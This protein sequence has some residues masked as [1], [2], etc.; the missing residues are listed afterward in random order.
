MAII[1]ILSP[2]VLLVAGIAFLPVYYIIIPYF[3][4]YRHL[5]GIPA[6]FPAQFTSLWLMSISRE[7][8]R[9]EYIDALHRRLGPVVRIQPNHVS[10]ADDKAINL[11]YG[12]GN[13]SL[14]S[15]WYDTFRS[16]GYSVFNTRDR[17]QHSHKRRIVAH[18]FAPKS[19]RQMEPCFAQNLKFLIEKWDDIAKDGAKTDGYADLDCRRWINFFA[20]DVIGDIIFGSPFGMLQAGADLAESRTTREGPSTLLPAVKHLSHRSEIAATL[21]AIPELKP[22]AQYIPDPYFRKGL[23][24]VK[25]F[26][27]V[28]IARV[29]DRWENPKQPEDRQDLL[30][31]LQEGSD[32]KGDAFGFEEL[33]AEALTLLIAGSDT[34]NNTFCAVM[35]HLAANPHAMSRLQEEVDAALPADVIVPTH[36]MVKNL[37]YL[38]SVINETLRQHSTIGLGLPRDVPPDSEGIHFRGHYFPAGTTLSVPI[39]TIHHSEEI[40]GQD[41][42]EYRPERWDNAT[43]QQKNAF[44]PFSTGP[45][46]C[47]GRNLVEMELKI[48]A[49]TW[50]KRYDVCMRQG[51]PEISEGLTRRQITMNIGIRRR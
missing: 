31:L 37:P 2:W 45:R 12:H 4:T 44:I 42:L 24:G 17:A 22:Y 38:N 50:A 14:K 8:K 11:V 34:T 7:N 6:P 26:T 27:G 36:D 28:A 32:D 48:L 30:S 40:W 16:I 23:E 21:G 9:S 13:R 5:R 29:K 49:A 25:S 19:V 46:A 51:P 47:L 3:W 33:T 41:A 43:A 1:P 15:A 35:N 20:F 18:T 39:Y 10:I